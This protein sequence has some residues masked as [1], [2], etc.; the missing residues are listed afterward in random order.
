MLDGF[1]EYLRQQGKS[2]NTVKSYCQGVKEYMRWHEETFGKRMKMLIRANVL[3]YISYLRTVKELNNRSVNAKLASL[4]SFNLYL[5]SAGYKTEVVLTKEDYLKVQT[6]YASPST[7]DRGEVERFRQ[8]ILENNGIRDY[9][10]VTIL[11]Y[12]GLRISECLELRMGDISLAAR[13]ITVRHGKGDKMRVVYFGNKVAN[14]VRE[15][16]KSRP[17]TENPYLFPGRGDSHLTRGQV[18]RIF[19]AHSASIT[20]HTL[21][22]F[23]CSNALEN[24]YSIGELANQAGHSNVHTTLLYTNPTKEKMKEKANLL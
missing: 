18:N 6:A 7:V 10:I 17:A 21:R 16:L 9:A 19:N 5:I 22:H 13:E 3:D 15:Y 2:E 23:F 20:P 14:A 12:A 8:E 11:A 4:H 1:C 24:G